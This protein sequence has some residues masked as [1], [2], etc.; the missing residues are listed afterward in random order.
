[1]VHL[2]LTYALSFNVIV[3]RS[4]DSYDSAVY[5]NWMAL[6]TDG[7]TFKIALRDFGSSIK[8]GCQCFPMDKQAIPEA[9]AYHLKLA[10]LLLAFPKY[11]RVDKSGLCQDDPVISVSSS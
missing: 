5:V 11:T 6:R 2:Q 1:M 9:I 4:S 7:L 3:L 10:V 8:S